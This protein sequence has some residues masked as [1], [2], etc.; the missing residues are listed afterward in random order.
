[1]KTLRL[2]VGGMLLLAAMAASAAVPAPTPRMLQDATRDLSFERNQGQA[3][4]DVR[5][6]ARGAGYVLMLTHDEARL[7][8]QA[9]ATD[10]AQPATEIR[11]RLLGAQP[12]SA[13][14]AEQPLATR[15]HYLRG[16]DPKHWQRDVPHYGRVRYHQ[17]YPGVDLVYYG[18]DHEL[19]YDFV[20]AP[21]ADP[22][23]VHLRY[24]GMQRAELDAQ[25]AL[26]L[27][28][29]SGVVT[30]KAPVAYQDI[31]GLSRPV[32]SAYRVRQGS[33]HVDVAFELGSYDAS[34]VLVI[35]PV[36]SYATYLGSR[37][38]DG[39][40]GVAVDAQGNIY[41]AGSTRFNDFPVTA[42][43]LQPGP[44]G[45][46]YDAFVSKLSAD[47][48]QLL[49]STYLGGSSFEVARGLTVDAAGSA[50]EIGR[51]HV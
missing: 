5:Y 43:A 7:H 49:Y 9:G 27:H 26:Q 11:S 10:D 25:G 48:T 19:E 21:G 51:A 14:E 4:A 50:Y 40:G 17:V 2:P 33:D 32:A 12:P 31:G 36:V 13:V 6:L 34:H 18:R 42:G 30:L 44:A 29:A 45:G 37:R 15:S 22:A 39:A 1:M 8:L 38:D 28:T 20:L 35:D 23:A 24:A 41:V 47:G 16:G 3:A 46:D